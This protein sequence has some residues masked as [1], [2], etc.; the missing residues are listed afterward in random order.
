ML[1]KG[2]R[3][4]KNDCEIITWPIEGTLG[5]RSDYLFIS[6]LICLETDVLSKRRKR[7]VVFHFACHLP[8]EAS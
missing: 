5:A 1:L 8:S 7:C 3:D 4:N 6:V 2:R